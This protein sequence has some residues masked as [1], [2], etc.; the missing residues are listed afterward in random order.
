MEKLNNIF[1]LGLN[2]WHLFETPPL[3]QARPFL[4]PVCREDVYPANALRI[5]CGNC[6]MTGTKQQFSAV[7][8]KAA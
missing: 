4:C 3:I 6:G 2:G 8:K 7:M 5:T 1:T